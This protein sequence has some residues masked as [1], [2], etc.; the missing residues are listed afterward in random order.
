MRKLMPA[1]AILAMIV[2]LGGCATK[3]YDDYAP[4]NKIRYSNNNRVNVGEFV[5]SAT[6]RG[7][8]SDQI[9]NTA[10][11]NFYIGTSV[12]ELVRKATREELKNAGMVIRDDAD[13]VV[14]GDVTVLKAADIGV[15]IDWSVGIAYTISKKS[16]NAK[17]FSR[18]YLHRATTGKLRWTQAAIV[19]VVHKQIAA[20]CDLFMRDPDVRSILDAPAR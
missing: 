4:Q 1:L 7:V 20:A 17:L 15:T 14:T 3:A 9:E 11:G 19:R 13:L 18:H 8:R 10:I 6:H 2:A 5:Y 16:T 12:A